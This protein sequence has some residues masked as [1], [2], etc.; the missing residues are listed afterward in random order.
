MAIRSDM[1]QYS[2]IENPLLW[3]I[4]EILREHPSVWKVHTLA[5]QL[6]VIGC[7][8]QLDK[9]QDKD[10]FKKNF[11]IMNALY[12][13]QEILYPEQWLTV[14]AMNI[15]LTSTANVSQ[16]S[17]DQIDPLRDYYL[18]W[19]Y[20]EANEDE[21]RGLLNEFW[22]SYQRYIGGNSATELDRARA[23]NVFE[24]DS[25]ATRADI[26]KQW[27]KLAFR[28]HPDRESGNAER[29]KAI[30]EAWNVLRVE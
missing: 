30:C 12:Q 4:F 9:S 23:L 2:D 18:N 1:R 20:Y 5:S 28:W 13:L 14:Q 25:S 16:T 26:R 17:I 19:E 11:L 24:L 29:F 27:R 6:S 3:P 15:E 10:L 7:L 21:V 8:H 22:H